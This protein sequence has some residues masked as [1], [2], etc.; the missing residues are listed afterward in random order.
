[1][2]FI[3]RDR[4]ENIL[5]KRKQ[6]KWIIPLLPNPDLYYFGF[7]LIAMLIL[8]HYFIVWEAFEEVFSVMGFAYALNVCFGN[9]PKTISS[10]A[11]HS[12]RSEGD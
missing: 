12:G 3:F 5:T 2:I 11:A 9:R 1:V 8:Y 10:G 7:M 4:L 6:S